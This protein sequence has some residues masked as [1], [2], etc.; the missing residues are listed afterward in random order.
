[1]RAIETAR[2]LQAREDEVALPRPACWAL[3]AVVLG[4][5]A[6]ADLVAVHR[7]GSGPLLEIVNTTLGHNGVRLGSAALLG[8]AAIWAGRRWL[9]ARMVGRP[10]SVEL[11]PFTADGGSAT[12]GV[13]EQVA[14]AVRRELSALSL[15]APT[16]VP[17]ENRPQNFVQAFRT[18]AGEAS[19]WV[20]AIP[21]V[22][23]WLQVT[24]G[25]EVSADLEERPG[26]LGHGMT[27]HVRAQ[28]AGPAQKTTVWGADW[29]E[30]ARRAADVVG[31]YILTRTTICRR[32]PWSAWRGRRLN[33]DLLR[34]HQDAQTCVQERR[35]EEALEHYYR[36]LKLDPLN[37]PIRIEVCQLREKL[38]NYLAALV[39]YVDLIVTESQKV[40]RRLARRITE[41]FCSAGTPPHPRDHRS[42]R[43][44]RSR[45]RGGQDSLMIARYRFVCALV[46]SDRVIDE[47][48]PI[49]DPA[50]DPVAPGSVTAPSGSWAGSAPDDLPQRPTRPATSDVGD[51][52]R[53]EINGIRSRERAESR[54]RMSSWLRLYYPKFV[55]DANDPRT[56]PA[57]Y[58]ELETADEETRARV[59]TCLL[60]YAATVEA[61]HL[62]RDYAWRRGRRR[63]GM[64]VSET[65]LAV[66][67]VWAPLHLLLV[68]K[69]NP[70]STPDGDR[71]RKRIGQGWPPDDLG[72]LE[73]E[74]R[75][76]LRRKPTSRREWQDNYNV[77]ASFAVLLLR[78]PRETTR[79]IDRPTQDGDTAPPDRDSVANVASRAVRYLELAINASSPAAL[80][81][82]EEWV[83]VGDQDLNGLRGTPQYV[84]FLERIFPGAQRWEQ[85]PYDLLTFLASTHFVTLLRDFAK[86]QV[87]AADADDRPAGWTTDLDEVRV[88]RSY[89]ADHADWRTRTPLIRAAREIA[90]AH[91]G[92]GS[93]HD[94]FPR[95]I[96]DP[97]LRSRN[98]SAAATADVDDYYETLTRLRHSFWEELTTKCHELEAA[99]E[100]PRAGDP[101][102]EYHDAVVGMWHGIRQ[103]CNAA[104][105]NDTAN[106]DAWK[107]EVSNRVDAR[108]ALLRPGDDPPGCD[109]TAR[110]SA[111]AARLRSSA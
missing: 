59:L 88:L 33:P 99:M 56:Y 71:L 102:P 5:L 105:R 43:S 25:Y 91:P 78:R 50:A 13:V 106:V 66:L 7:A 2:R 35:Y 97:G 1:M 72:A 98:P 44:H 31:A 42:R 39:G 28:P 41:D 61:R 65:S 101:P 69:G 8:I 11:L 77:A 87:V 36:A 92:A 76:A 80:A 10:G 29:D 55:V 73:T 107:A 58:D 53:P 95:F 15:T 83:A 57:T 18:A 60:R 62:A 48:T 93:V 24:T 67:R 84:D 109:R 19:N 64:P 81:E 68:T 6:V 47:W 111:D 26:A 40:D 34:A 37:I 85:R 14:A 20:Q 96:D 82:Y 23:D 75:K 38:G 104:L 16:P 89:S 103:L 108:V 22:L 90:A 79:D 100:K 51:E 86:L 4:G 54:R 3:L 9:Y 46:N 52:E 74:L 30:T 21:G 12:D 32:G 17:G 70:P 63:P 27:V 49:E 110:R 94:S 45:R